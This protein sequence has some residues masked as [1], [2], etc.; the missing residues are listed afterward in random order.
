MLKPAFFLLLGATLLC[1]CG[2]DGG[3]DGSAD[4]GSTCTTNADCDDG[5]YCNGS[6]TC[7]P[8]V[9][10]V[11]SGCL[12]GTPPCPSGATCDETARTCD[13]E[14]P[15]ADG[16]G[17]ASVD[18]GGTDCDDGDADAF[19][20]NV[21]VCDSEGVD[22]DCDPT[23]LG[24]DADGDGYVDDECCNRDS[25][26][27]LECGQDCNDSSSDINPEAVDACG[28]GD[29]DCDG[30]IDEEP[31]LTFYRDIDGDGFGIP[32]DTVMACGAPGGYALLDTDCN[33]MV[34]MTNPAA[35]ERCDVSAGETPDPMI[36]DND[37]D[38]AIDEGCECMEGEDR[39]CGGT[40]AMAMVGTCRPGTQACQ[41]TV[42]GTEW[43]SCSSIE[44]AASEVC[45]GQDDDCDGNTDEAFDCRRNQSVS[46]STACG[47]PGTRRCSG[48]CT[49]LD[50]GFY[51]P[52]SN[53]TCDYCDDTGTGIS[54]ERTTYATSMKTLTIDDTSTR[55]GVAST[56]SGSVALI[57]GGTNTAGA[58]VTPAQ[59]LGH[60]NV[61]FEALLD[62]V[63]GSSSTPGEGWALFV[64]RATAGN[65]IGSSGSALGVPRN[66]DGFAVEWVFNGNGSDF[67]R[68][69]HLRASS[70]SDP[71]VDSSG[72]LNPS[73]NGATSGFIDQ[74]FRVTA[75]P[76]VP[77][78][79][80]NE[81][82]VIVQHIGWIGEPVVMECGPSATAC[83]FRLTPGLTYYFG[84][85]AATSS[86]V[87]NV[88]TQVPDPVTITLRNLCAGD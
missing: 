80:A 87:A 50:A 22:E 34:A 13:G 31:E 81:T 48:S 35:T 59:V 36:H 43:G 73:L 19:P 37:C 7:D 11:A 63:K 61:T 8:S 85:S 47:N 62:V 84:V 9:S 75:T 24:P 65:P 49:W 15:D 4:G 74:G 44:P 52:E 21:E 1:A 72:T 64:V 79:A 60:G 5:T 18:C 30:D 14:C 55:Y 6:E 83:G 71:V 29:Q 23:T 54:S 88:Y 78:T 45:D 41:T 57:S 69:R 76:D 16:D 82:A 27:D 42:G 56:F 51:S 20:G 26:G 2:D 68:I 46:G 77:G 33:D 86:N 39:A 53:A 58:A 3:G 70:T 25:S 67:G 32:G 66:K 12:A 10:T 38:G 40:E 17:F 28:S